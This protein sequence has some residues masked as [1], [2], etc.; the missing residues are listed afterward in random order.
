M[1]EAPQTRVPLFGR[2]C[3][4]YLFVV[5]VFLLEVGFYYFVSR[6]FS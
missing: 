1:N 6:F 4:A 2:W 5:L 3:N